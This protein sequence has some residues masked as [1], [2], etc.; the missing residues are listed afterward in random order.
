VAEPLGGAIEF[1]QVG[2]GAGM[3]DF[4]STPVSIV[5]LDRV[6]GQHPKGPRSRLSPA[7]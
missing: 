1:T 6:L 7:S 5:E 4:A 2:E 3:N